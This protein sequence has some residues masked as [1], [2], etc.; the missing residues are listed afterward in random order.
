M[1]YVTLV[2]SVTC[3][4]FFDGIHV[5]A[6]M[7]MYSFI[8][9]TQLCYVKWK[10]KI[11]IKHLD[12]KWSDHTLVLSFFKKEKMGNSLKIASKMFEKTTYR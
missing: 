9:I 10:Q 6:F 2:P 3:L 7:I 4:A 12:I 1:C 5:L 8:Y 11:N